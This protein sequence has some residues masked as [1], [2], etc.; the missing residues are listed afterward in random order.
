[1]VLHTKANEKLSSRRH[2]QG[3]AGSQSRMFESLFED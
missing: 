1:M 3:V 2:A